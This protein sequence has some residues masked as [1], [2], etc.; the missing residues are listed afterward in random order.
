MQKTNAI[1]VRDLGAPVQ[2]LVPGRR[3]DPRFLAQL[4][5]TRHGL[6]QTRAKMRA[7]PKAGAA[8]YERCHVP[9]RGSQRLVREL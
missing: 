4:I 9:A 8:A 7:A 3:P 2:P 5:A 6:M 1:A